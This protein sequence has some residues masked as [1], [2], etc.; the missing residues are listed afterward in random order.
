M[1]RK[2]LG[3]IVLTI[4]ATLLAGVVAQGLNPA[5][6]QTIPGGGPSSNLSWRY[7]DYVM[8]PMNVSQNNDI[9]AIVDTVTQ[10]ILYFEY[11]TNAKQ[12]VPYT[13]G[14]EIT[15]ELGSR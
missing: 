15:Q 7:S 6:A 12:L 1:D 2:T 14:T 9:L 11:D 13:K 5:N 4:T 3:I 10:R 8:V